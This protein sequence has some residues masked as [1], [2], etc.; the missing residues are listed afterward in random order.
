[1]MG[2]GL[3]LMS[4]GTGL[5]Q[6][7]ELVQNSRTIDHQVPESVQLADERG[8]GHAAGP[9]AQLGGQHPQRQQ[10]LV[11]LM[12][13]PPLILNDHHEMG[14]RSFAFADEFA[15]FGVGF[16]QQ[17]GHG[18]QSG[19]ATGVVRG[20]FVPDSAQGRMRR[21]TGELF[22]TGLHFEDGQHRFEH[23]Q[24][25]L[26]HDETAPVRNAQLK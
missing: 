7:L 6:L 13:L 26:P 9:S 17:C 10:I 25:I 18:G 11:R 12:T 15:Q 24:G 4:I 16:L 23:F 2:N 3:T 5:H 1:M 21:S 14:G 8:I 19:H 20:A 22:Q